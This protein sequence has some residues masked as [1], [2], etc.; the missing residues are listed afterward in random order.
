MLV[1]NLSYSGSVRAC[2]CMRVCVCV[3]ANLRNVCIVLHGKAFYTH[4]NIRFILIIIN[5]CHNA[6][7][8]YAEWEYRDFHF[9]LLSDDFSNKWL[10]RIVTLASTIVSTFQWNHFGLLF[11]K[12][13]FFVQR[14][15]YIFRLSVRHLDSHHFFFWINML[16]KKVA[17]ACG[18][19]LAHL[20]KCI[21]FAA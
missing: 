11:A 20:Y 19:L 10:H 17:V 1:R 13:A 3:F 18:H 8:T 7:L 15:S 2:P 6:Y 5:N 16:T 9:C 12:S 21:R 4:N 14:W